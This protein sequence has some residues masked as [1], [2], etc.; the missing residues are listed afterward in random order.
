MHCLA[1]IQMSNLMRLQDSMHKSHLQIYC[2]PCKSGNNSHH[3]VLHELA[4]AG[5]YDKDPISM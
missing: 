4:A 1:T 2:I 5:E 3:L